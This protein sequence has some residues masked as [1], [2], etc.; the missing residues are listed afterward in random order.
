MKRA[1]VVLA[2][3]LALV[4]A[5]SKQE[6]KQAKEDVQNTATNVAQKVEDAIDVAVPL[7]GKDDPAAREKERFDENWRGVFQNTKVQTAPQGPQ[8]P[9]VQVT[10]AANGKESFAAFK[11]PEAINTAPVVVPLKGDVSG[12]SVLKTQVYLDRN[13]FSVGALD[14]RWGRNSAI[15]LW[16]Y[17]RSR[18]INAA[19]PGALDEPTFRA[20][21]AS[22]GGVPALI[23]H[24]LTAD[25]LEGPFVSVPDDMY[26]KAELDCLCYESLKEKLAERFH[27]SMDFLDQL[28]EEVRFSDLKAGDRIWVP[29]VRPALEQDRRDIA[30]VV[31]SI[32]GNTFNA[33]DASGNLIFHAP[34]TLGSKY[35]PS[36]NETVSVKKIVHDPHFHYQPKLFAE[37]PDDEPEANLNPGP[38]SPVGV[39]WVALSKPHFGVHGT[40]DPDSI[41]Y[42]SSHGCVRLTNWD[43]KEVA[44]RIA[45]GVQIEFLD[46]REAA[47]QTASR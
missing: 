43:A 11:T 46:T 29:N 28:N 7:G 19:E 13:G 18:G 34:T 1:P 14:G 8:A 25:D 16:W 36:P 47:T 35:D 41:G 22:A 23:Q 9:E 42:A 38:N 6:A 5:C 26:E 45:E 20:L 40:S 21:A 2:A 31:V 17:Q 39:V 15:A 27:T 30:R 32:R 3:T 44:H 37:V 33:F 4:A 24:T 12:P 10:F